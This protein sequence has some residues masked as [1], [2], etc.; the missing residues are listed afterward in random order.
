MEGLG[1]V[2]FSPIFTK[3][4]TMALE[5]DVSIASAASVMLGASPI[6][7]FDEDTVE[8]ETA[9]AVY[10]SVY[11]NLLSYRPWTFARDYKTPVLITETPETGYKF[12]YQLGRGV[13]KVLDLGHPVPYRL[14]GGREL[15]TDIK[16]PRVQVLLKPKEQD[17]PQDF[18]YA[19]KCL[20]A[21]AM[22][23]TITD[24]INQAQY[25]DKKGTQLLQ[26]A[27]DNDLAQEPMESILGHSD[28]MDSRFNRF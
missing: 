14:I 28:F 16:N 24:N 19:F 15:H 11:E 2:P 8:A 22:A 9:K 13:V 1:L 5:S 10:T 18:I 27:A 3:E 20:L 26:Q 17:L 12:S 4:A 7:S 23:P 25:Y 21:A 6:Q